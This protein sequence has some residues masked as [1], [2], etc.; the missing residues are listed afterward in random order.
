[1]KKLL[2]REQWNSRIRG[3]GR[4]FSTLVLVKRLSVDAEMF[5]THKIDS[6]NTEQEWS[7]PLR[8]LQ[9]GKGLETLATRT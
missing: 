9:R 4:C 7:R 1:L 3:L 8:A 2:R 5:E 6:K